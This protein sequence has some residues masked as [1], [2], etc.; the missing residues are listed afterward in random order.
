L[1]SLT[2]TIEQNESLTGRGTSDAAAD[3]GR[4]V[5]DLSNEPI[6]SSVSRIARR[7]GYASASA[8]YRRRRGGGDSGSDGSS[9]GSRKKGLYSEKELLALEET[10]AEGL[11]AVQ[12]VELFV[13]RGV[14]LSEASFRKYVQQGLLPR[15]RRVGRKGKHRGSMGMYPS[16][17]V[18]RL[19]EIKQLMSE[20]YTIEEIQVQFLRFSSVIESIREGFSELFGRLEEDLDEPRFDKQTRR[21]VK[22]EMRSVQKAADELMERLDDITDRVIRRRGDE[23]RNPSAAGGAEDLL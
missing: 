11:T 18:R 15:S 9:G 7:S 6:L 14:R 22:S 2:S 12:A 4:S 21:N 8:S 16:K 23:Y 17:T 13:S 20:G 19:N 3:D 1:S 5:V 10:Y